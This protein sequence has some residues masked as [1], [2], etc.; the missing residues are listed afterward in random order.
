[1]GTNYYFRENICKECNHASKETHIGKSSGGWTFSFHATDT[2]KSWVHWQLLLD[3]DVGK[4]FDEYERE[5]SFAEF[6]K[7]VEDRGDNLLNHAKEHP[8]GCFLDDKGYSFSTYE[9]C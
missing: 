8:E 5:L 1:M 2:E 9:F 6:K 3:S 4:I 7:I